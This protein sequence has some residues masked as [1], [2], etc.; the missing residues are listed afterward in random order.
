MSCYSQ[1]KHF[2]ISTLYCL[3]QAENE[4][5]LTN[6]EQLSGSTIVSH[7]QLYCFVPIQ[8]P[9]AHHYNLRFVYFLPHFSVRLILQ[10]IYVV[11]NKES[12]ASNPR[13]IIKSSFKSRVGYNGA[14]TVVKY[15]ATKNQALRAWF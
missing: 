9:Y 13:I 12:W 8:I 2:H 3:H 7:G 1:N 11:L 6:I 10:T 5:Q 4:Q 15:I 14:R